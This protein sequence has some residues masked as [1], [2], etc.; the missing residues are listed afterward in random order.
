MINSGKSFP[1]VK[2]LTATGNSFYSQ[3]FAITGTIETDVLTPKL[4]SPLPLIQALPH[5]QLT[6][7]SKVKIAS[8]SELDNVIGIGARVILLD[9]LDSSYLLQNEVILMNGKTPVESINSFSKVFEITVIQLGTNTDVETGDL[10]SVGDIY[11]GTGTFTNGIPAN[12]IIGIKASDNN[13][14]SREAIFTVPDGK[15][16][17]IRGIFCTTTPDKKEN[18]NIEIEVCFNLFGLDVNQW[19]KSV[20]YNFDAM[21]SYEYEA[22]LLAPPRTNIQVRGRTT[23]LKTKKATVEMAVEMVDASRI[24]F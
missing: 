14:N 19:Y 6:T 22:L 18:N 16:L 5:G 4:I 21:Y 2:F 11:C 12:P 8:T 9:G 13:L 1:D 10:V 15:F 20:P 24:S 7:P 17:L 3:R 23:F